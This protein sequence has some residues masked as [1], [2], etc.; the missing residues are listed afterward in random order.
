MFSLKMRDDHGKSPTEA[1]LPMEGA[2]QLEV[3]T[4]PLMIPLR[5]Q[6]RRHLATHRVVSAGE[7]E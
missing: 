7:V 5:G 3:L 4:A 1:A 2:F 6:G